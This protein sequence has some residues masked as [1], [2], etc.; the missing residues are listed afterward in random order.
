MFFFLF[1]FSVLVGYTLATSTW[2]VCTEMEVRLGARG[3][4][5][6]AAAAAA[7]AQLHAFV[8]LEHDG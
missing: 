1:P 6:I 2:S 3:G 8:T 4:G 7:H 5:V